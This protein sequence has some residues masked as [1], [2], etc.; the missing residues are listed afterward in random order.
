MGEVNLL[1]IIRSNTE[2][3]S[4]LMKRSS[5]VSPVQKL[6]RVPGQKPAKSKESFDFN[7]MSQIILEHEQDNKARNKTSSRVG[8]KV[9]HNSQQIAIDDDEQQGIMAA[10]HGIQLSSFNKQP[11]LK[12]SEAL[13]FG[14]TPMRSKDES[15]QKP[16]Q[17]TVKKQ[18]SPDKRTVKKV[19]V[20]D[21]K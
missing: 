18:S 1:R 3:N 9:G 21:G 16:R 10:S 19:S 5:T 8:S 15:K 17:P 20:G 6:P 13:G 4:S 7:R 2:Q 11:S 14:D 12:K